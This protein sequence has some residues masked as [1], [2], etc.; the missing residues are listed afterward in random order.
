MDKTSAQELAEIDDRQAALRAL[1]GKLEMLKLR[2]STLRIGIR[3]PRSKGLQQHQIRKAMAEM[4]RKRQG[5]VKLTRASER[6]SSRQSFSLPTETDGT[7]VRQKLPILFLHA[8]AGTGLP[9]KDLINFLA[10]SSP[11]THPIAKAVLCDCVC[12]PA[13]AKPV[14]GPQTVAQAKA[15]T[16]KSAALDIVAKGA[17][18]NRVDRDVLRVGNMNVKERV[19]ELEAQ[20]QAA[21]LDRESERGGGGC[22]GRV[23]REKRVVRGECV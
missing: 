3:L 14:F 9:E 17:V 6:E 5:R 16:K 22:V 2:R 13:T 21:H 4:Y 10:Q 7:T 1:S 11:L 12:K 23:K 20:L 19:R 15:A 18:D 8:V